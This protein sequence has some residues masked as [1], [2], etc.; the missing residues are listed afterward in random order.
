LRTKQALRQKIFRSI[1]GI[2]SAQR[3]SSA[4]RFAA[5]GGMAL[6]FVTKLL[7]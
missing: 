5:M 3:E 1:A 2:S 6:K 7:K 4:A